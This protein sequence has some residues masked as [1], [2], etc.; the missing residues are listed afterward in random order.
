MLAITLD[1]VIFCLKVS[2]RKTG[3]GNRQQMRHF[4]SFEESLMQF[5]LS[6]LA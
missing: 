2:Y 6:V 4:Q 3:D 5:M 1:A